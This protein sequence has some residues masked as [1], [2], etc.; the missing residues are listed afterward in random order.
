MLMARLLSTAQVAK[1]R[2][3][4]VRTVQLWIAEGKIRAERTHGDRGQWRI[5]PEDV[6]APT[7]G[8]EDAEDAERS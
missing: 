3:V 1:L 6:P 4:S 7:K 8:E 2:G 5:R